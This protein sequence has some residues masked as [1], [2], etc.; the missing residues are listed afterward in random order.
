MHKCH[1][2]SEQKMDHSGALMEHIFRSVDSSRRS[3]KSFRSHSN[4]TEN[5]THTKLE[6]CMHY[7][8]QTEQQV[9]VAYIFLDPEWVLI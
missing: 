7:F 3:V 6:V 4:K 2:L 5:C 8:L 1:V 9:L